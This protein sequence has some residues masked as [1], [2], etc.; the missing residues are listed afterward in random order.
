M[1]YW[2]SVAVINLPD[3]M[4]QQIGLCF[5]SNVDGMRRQIHCM[6]DAILHQHKAQTHLMH[7]TLQWLV[8]AE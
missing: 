6:E 8:P 4:H 5:T 7:S 2:K 1:Q 3:G